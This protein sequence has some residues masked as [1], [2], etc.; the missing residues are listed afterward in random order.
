MQNR[1]GIEG[2]TIQLVFELYP[3]HKHV[4]PEY[5]Q[6]GIILYLL[7]QKMI[8]LFLYE[9]SIDEH[10]EK[11]ILRFVWY[12]QR[13]NHESEDFPKNNFSIKSFFKYKFLPKASRNS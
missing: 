4:W 8:R 12:F 10:L 13:S 2:Y 6:P 5:G 11:D 7:W 3:N 1:L 9:R